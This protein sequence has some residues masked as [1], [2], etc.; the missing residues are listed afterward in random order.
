MCD[1]LKRDLGF[2]ESILERLE[3]IEEVTQLQMAELRERIQV[4]SIML[5]KK[6]VKKND[7]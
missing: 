7:N 1:K 5:K 4:K 6:A 3:K 2:L